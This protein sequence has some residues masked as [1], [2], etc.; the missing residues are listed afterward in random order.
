MKDDNL[1]VV[2]AE[3]SQVRLLEMNGSSDD[4]KA[5]MTFLNRRAINVSEESS[6]LLT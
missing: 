6:W 4:I 3:S 1:C 5:N 2:A